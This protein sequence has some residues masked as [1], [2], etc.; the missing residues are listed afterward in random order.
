MESFLIE[1]LA[2]RMGC[3]PMA[4]IMAPQTDGNC[5]G[6][7]SNC[8][9][10]HSGVEPDQSGG[11]CSNCGRNCVESVFVLAGF[12]NDPRRGWV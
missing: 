2:D 12:F 8:H 11:F 6:I 3:S 7:C 9:E 5:P 4:L 1:H 10:P